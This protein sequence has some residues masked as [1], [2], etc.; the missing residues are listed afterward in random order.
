MVE[1]Q[2]KRFY[3]SKMFWANLI[4]AGVIVAEIEFGT[5]VPI[6]LQALILSGINILLRLLT[7]K[8]IEGMP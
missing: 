3:H 4:A 1:E 7:K 6:E 5:P 8:G 2:K